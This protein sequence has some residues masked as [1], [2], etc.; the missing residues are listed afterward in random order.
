LIG[1]PF[2]LAQKLVKR[3]SAHCSSN[4]FARLEDT[5][6][7]YRDPIAWADYKRSLQVHRAKDCYPN[8]IGLAQLLI[9]EAADRTRLSPRALRV[10]EEMQRKYE[11]TGERTAYRGSHGGWVHSP[12]ASEHLGELSNKHWLQ[13]IQSDVSQRDGRWRRVKGGFVEASHE[14]FARDIG[15]AA[16][17]DPNRFA[18]LLLQIDPKA[19]AS[20]AAA[21]VSAISGSSSYAHSAIQDEGIVSHIGFT[22]NTELAIALCRFMRT[23]VTHGLSSGALDLLT[24]YA[25]SHPHPAPDEFIVGK[26]EGEGQERH[27]V[28]D[29]DVS[30]INC[31]RGVAATALRALLFESPSALSVVRSAIDSLVA[32]PAGSV[33][34]AAVGICLPILNV[35]RTLA[36]DYFV[37]AI[38][39]PDDRVLATE[40]VR[41]FLSY[42]IVRDTERVAP[43]VH[44]MLASIEPEVC[45][46]GASWATVGWLERGSFS[47][48]VNDS[49]L[50][51]APRRLGVARVLRTTLK[52]KGLRPEAVEILSRLFDDDDKD[53]RHEAAGVFWD[54]DVLDHPEAVRLAQWLVESKSLFD[55]HTGFFH[56]L[57]EHTGA[58][59]PFGPVFLRACQR[60]EAKARE[61]KASGEWLNADVYDLPRLVL[62]LYEEIDAQSD[63]E[64][65][66]R[67]LDMW[68]AMLRAGIGETN[69]LLERLF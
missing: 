38:D 67:C 6:L 8:D 13:I 1:S 29:L 5:I 61:S 66:T 31:V 59:R 18:N 54:A 63:P 2:T 22:E 41:Q 57:T 19:N 53:V 21:I 30:S 35:D 68:D 43:V 60:M 47:D 4:T 39:F 45:E 56:R 62:R 37:R 25:M 69:V 34:A 44:R 16:T 24:R 51:P 33:R 64:G 17:Q 49:L 52:R 28:N 65:H 20:Y 26:Y 7:T 50:G 15:Q 11:G 48:C 14:M 10:L 23:M 32:D 12:I 9:L 3:H 55:A 40:Q 36:I 58:I 42:T 27:G 46:R